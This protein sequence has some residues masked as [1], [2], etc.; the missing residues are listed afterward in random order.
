MLRAG[1]EADGYAVRTA[2]SGREALNLL[3]S[4]PSTCVI[5]LDLLL[6]GMDGM[7][8][9]TVQARDRSLAWIPVVIISAAIDAPRIAR[10]IGARA[11]LPKPVDIDRVRQ[12]VRLIGCAYRARRGDARIDAGTNGRNPPE[13]GRHQ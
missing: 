2:T 5:L 1:L 8:F 12:T 6:P 9:R 13:I 10:E 3:R 11:F 7:Q 4:T